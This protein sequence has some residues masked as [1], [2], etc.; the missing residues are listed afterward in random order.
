M[1]SNDTALCALNSINP[2]NRA[3]AMYSALSQLYNARV[4]TLKTTK[5]VFSIKLVH[6]FKIF[7]QL[8][9][10]GSSAAYF[11]FISAISDVNISAC[12]T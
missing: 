7:T 1:I 2:V 10:S 5:S 11:L 8:S 12:C 9:V 6:P 3:P 4:V